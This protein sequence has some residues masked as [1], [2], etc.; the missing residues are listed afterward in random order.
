MGSQKPSTSELDWDRKKF[1]LPSQRDGKKLRK[2]SVCSRL[3][4][5]GGK[6]SIFPESLDFGEKVA[7]TSAILGLGHRINT[8]P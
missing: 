2:S 6:A 8:S 7:M 4:A 3:A 1:I 5:I